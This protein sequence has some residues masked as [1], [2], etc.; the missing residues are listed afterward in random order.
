LFRFDSFIAFD[1]LILVFPSTFPK[2]APTI[3]PGV[4]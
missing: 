1:N 4:C 3:T 2:W